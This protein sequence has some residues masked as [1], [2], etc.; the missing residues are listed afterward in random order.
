MWHR[1]MHET[2]FLSLLKGS[3]PLCQ[4]HHS[5]SPSSFFWFGEPYFVWFISGS[6]AYWQ[7]SMA[8]RRYSG[9]YP[10]P[11]GRKR[12]EQMAICLPSM[13]WL[14]LTTTDLAM[15]I[16]SFSIAFRSRTCG[17]ISSLSLVL[18]LSLFNDLWHLNLPT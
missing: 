18:L 15:R 6:F 2:P 16:Y 4:T 3:L 1:D 13:S 17:T 14:A 12:T 9:G 10:T 8:A 7:M 5:V 11:R